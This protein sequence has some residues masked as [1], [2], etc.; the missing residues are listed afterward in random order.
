MTICVSLCDTI[1]QSFQKCQK[2]GANVILSNS[3]GGVVLLIVLCGSKTGSAVLKKYFTKNKMYNHIVIVCRNF[4]LIPTLCT[5][6]VLVLPLP[7]DNFNH[8][9]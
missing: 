5:V 3:N 8:R 9:D 6:Q 2:Y 7:C 1:N 4:I